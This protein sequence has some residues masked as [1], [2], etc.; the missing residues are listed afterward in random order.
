MRRTSRSLWA[1]G[2]GQPRRPRAGDGED[3]TY[4]DSVLLEMMVVLRLNVG[5]DE[6]SE[7]GG[8]CVAESV[9]ESVAAVVVVVSTCGAASTVPARARAT[10][11]TSERAKTIVSNWRVCEGVGI[12]VLYNT[13]VQ[14][15]GGAGRREADGVSARGA[16][17]YIYTLHARRP[18]PDRGRRCQTSVKY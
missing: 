18:T 14:A 11:Y 1:G 16:R 5:R 13:N 15:Y 9:A 7:M 3:A 6:V 10:K 8:D 2:R 17:L 4:E 12:R